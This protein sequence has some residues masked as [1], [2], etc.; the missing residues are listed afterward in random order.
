[1]ARTIR[2]AGVSFRPPSVDHSKGVNLAAVRDIVQQVA[3]D[4]PH[5]IAFPEL[6]ACP[7]N[8]E[9][10]VRNAVELKPF[11]EEVGKLAREVGIAL[12]VPF[13][14]RDGKQVF[15]SVPIVDS[16]GKLALVYRKN[17]P[18]DSELRGGVT[19]GTQVPV[20]VCDGVRVGAAVC[21]D[22]NFSHVWSELE[23]GR[24]RVVFYPTMYWAGRHLEYYASRFGYY[25]V[26]A[27]LGDSAIVDMSG[28]HLV[29][30]GQN[31]YFVKQK[32]LP[33]WAIAEVAIDR[34][35]YHLDYNQ[36]K[37][38][39][40]RKKYGPGVL[41]EIFEEEDFCLITSRID[42]VSVEKIAAEFQLE[43]MRE[44]F[45]RSLKLRDEVLRT[46]GKRRD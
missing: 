27:Y 28:R 39:A 24:A 43:T 4:K 13:A 35:V 19:P 18:T 38:D 32:K 34:E 23:A 40:V 17:Y 41:I 11:V 16:Q 44:Y 1:M 20:A 46:H 15:N 2:L 7:G 21:F 22:A 14:E 36:N 30:Q 3:R 25:I 12:V 8:V 29:R 42:G 26:R 9:T 5:F 6:C 33:P 10:A 31:S 45:A 37:L